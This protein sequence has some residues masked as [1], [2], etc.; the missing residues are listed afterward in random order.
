MPNIKKKGSFFLL[1]IKVNEIKIALTKPLVCIMHAFKVWKSFNIGSGTSQFWLLFFCVSL[2]WKFAFSCFFFSLQ[3]WWQVNFGEKFWFHWG[4]RHFVHQGACLLSPSPEQSSI[5]L[6]SSCTTCLVYFSSCAG[7]FQTPTSVACFHKISVSESH[8]NHSEVW[9]SCKGVNYQLV[10]TDCCWLNSLNVLLALF[11]E[12][13]K[14]QII[15]M[16]TDLILGSNH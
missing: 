8:R 1:E 11:K 6:E 15:F 13:W 4:I 3:T 10:I 12:F 9:L 16:F 14:V 2:N 5:Q 7:V